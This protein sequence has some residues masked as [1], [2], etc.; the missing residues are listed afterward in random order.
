MIFDELGNAIEARILA[1]LGTFFQTRVYQ[2]ASE[3]AYVLINNFP[4][5][6]CSI[7]YRGSTENPE[8]KHGEKIYNHTF[9][10]YAFQVVLVNQGAV[11]GFGLT[12]GLKKILNE[13]RSK[14]D[15]YIFTTELTALSGTIISAR[16]GTYFGTGDFIIPGE[17]AGYAANIGLQI[18]YKEHA[19]E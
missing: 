8:C 9:D 11:K 14:L 17:N 10:I 4:G 2:L 6:G 18:T 7:I 3:T 19:Y 5:F 16:I 12:K 15:N 1:Q 13:I